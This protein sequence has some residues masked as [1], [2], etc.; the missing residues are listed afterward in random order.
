[1]Q[2][3]SVTILV[4]PGFIP[5]E[6]ALVQDPLRIANRLGLGVEFDLRICTT[7]GSD[8]VESLGGLLVRATPLP[9]DETT[10]PDHLVVLGGKG[11][12]TSFANLRARLRWCERRGQNI[13]LMSDAATEWQR[14]NPQTEQLT[15]HWEHQ[16]LRDTVTCESHGKLPLFTETG[17]I[18][19][20]AGMLSA[21]DV[22]LSLIVARY[23]TRLAQA[24]GNILLVD[25]I[26]QGAAEQPR[27]ENDVNALRVARLESAIAEMEANLEDP[28]PISQLAAHA[29][30]SVRQFER[31]FKLFIGQTPAAFYRA[32]RLRRARVLL[33][34]TALPVFEVALAC[35]FGCTSNFSKLFTREFGI[36]PTKYQTR[37]LAMAH[38][39]RNDLQS[40][41]PQDAPFP[42]SACSSRTSAHPVG[43][44]ETLV[45]GI[46]R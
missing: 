15:T 39:A 32:L 23:N 38:D 18:A 36:S 33:E 19:T 30:V 10:L 26:R 40:Q 28:L 43:A 24:V 46:G 35:G 13:I 8:L 14:I 17:R 12:R 1:M 25:R 27:S 4:E 6:L 16:Q 2:R 5:T 22:T 21:A 20:S 42:L 34:Q 7:S 29:G 31:R 44:D 3:V 37:F 41:G 45:Q 11:I 9:L